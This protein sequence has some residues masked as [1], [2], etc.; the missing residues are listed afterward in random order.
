M[1]GVFVET[2][3]DDYSDL[4]VP[5][6][7]HY[8]LN[9]TEIKKNKKDRLVALLFILEIFM[10]LT[11]HLSFKVMMI[12]YVLKLAGPHCHCRNIYLLAYAMSSRVTA[13]GNRSMNTTSISCGVE[14]WMH[15]RQIMQILLQMV[16]LRHISIFYPMIT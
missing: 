4:D 9:R 13:V 12:L 6:F 5:N 8:V 3:T 10:W 11:K 15:V 2:W 16:I 1:L 7:E 14:T